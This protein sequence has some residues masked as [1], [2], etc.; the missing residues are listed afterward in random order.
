VEEYSIANLAD[1]TAFD[2]GTIEMAGEREVPAGDDV[3]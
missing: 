2:A 3:E 1:I